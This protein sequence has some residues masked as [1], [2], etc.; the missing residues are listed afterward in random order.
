[1]L[2]EIH[3]TSKKYTRVDLQKICKKK[4]KSPS[5]QAMID[6]YKERT[7]LPPPP[8]YDTLKMTF[9]IVKELGGTEEITL[10]V[11]MARFKNMRDEN[12]PFSVVP[13]N[14]AGKQMCRELAVVLNSNGFYSIH[15]KKDLEAY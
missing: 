4:R 9:H 3:G 1:M 6:E 2:G 11:D 12:D 14:T 10:E 13:I 15:Y 5:E 8:I 7:G